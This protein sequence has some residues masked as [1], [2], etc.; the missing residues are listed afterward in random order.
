MGWGQRGGRGGR[1]RVDLERTQ[2]G[3]SMLCLGDG[4]EFFFF[5][6]FSPA[7]GGGLFG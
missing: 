5:F 1:V 4:L 2:N 6:F 3:V 7:N